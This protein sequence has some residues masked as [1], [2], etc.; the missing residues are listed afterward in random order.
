MLMEILLRMNRTVISQNI[1]NDT[2]RELISIPDVYHLTF[3][4]QPL[5]PNSLNNTLFRFMAS[6]DSQIITE[7]EDTFKNVETALGKAWTNAVN[8]A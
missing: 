6:R 5:L 3:S 2:L 8:K 4:F 1:S 7:K